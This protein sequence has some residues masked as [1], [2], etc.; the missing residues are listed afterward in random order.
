MEA[1]KLRAGAS[2]EAASDTEGSPAPTPADR[3]LLLECRL[4]EL[5]SS[6]AEARAEADRARTRLAEAAAREADLA[7]HH[8]LVQEELAA[9]RDEVATLHRRLERSE[10]LRAGM[11]GR[12]F[13]AGSDDAEELVRLRREASGTRG[14]TGAYR[15]TMSHMRARIEELV[16]TREVLLTRVVEWQR[17]VREGDPEALDLAEFITAL[18]RDILELEHQNF[19]GERR[20]AELRQRL[21]DPRGDTPAGTR[22]AAEVETHADATASRNATT[23]TSEAAI[24]PPEAATDARETAID[25]EAVTDASET[26]IDPEAVTDASETAIDPEAAADVRGPEGEASGGD[27]STHIAGSDPE[28]TPDHE[29]A[30]G[31]LVGALSVVRDPRRR[32]DLLLRLGRSGE[33]EAFHAVRPSATASEPDERAAAFQ[34]LG[35]LLERDPARL[36]PYLRWGISDADA[37]VRRRVILA[38]AG[39]RG[40]EL[41]PLLEPLRA[42][43]DPQ[44]RRLVNEVLRG[45]PPVAPDVHDPSGTEPADPRP[46]R[47]ASGVAP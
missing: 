4:E 19:L 15:Q 32:I 43:P 29:A 6:L 46:A 22:D 9:A 18:R 36:E 2:T 37:R 25:P 3:V 28:G 20:E 11:E 24:D 1:R 23:E 5:R 8:G 45:R 14:E 12:I 35:R 38:A 39:A 7:R 47:T 16:A 42:D 17:A 33:E 26:P 10:A 34:A 30:G 27:R 31:D 41:R 40:L 21:L 13:E 44:V